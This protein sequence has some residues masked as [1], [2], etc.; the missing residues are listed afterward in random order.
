MG[1][2]SAPGVLASA[3][4]SSS[5]LLGRVLFRPGL[6]HSSMA[7][8]SCM[9]RGQDHSEQRALWRHAHGNPRALA[10]RPA[11][12]LLCLPLTACKSRRPADGLPMAIFPIRQCKSLSGHERQAIGEPGCWG[13]LQHLDIFAYTACTSSVFLVSVGHSYCIAKGTE[14]RLKKVVR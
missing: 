9:Q 14:G 7:P 12:M 11:I 10:Y 2:S 5:G 3:R 4:P 8:G 13:T 6:G 1:C